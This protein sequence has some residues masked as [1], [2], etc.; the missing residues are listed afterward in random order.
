MGLVKDGYE[1]F[2]LG[3]HAS[4]ELIGGIA[5][6]EAVLGPLTECNPAHQTEAR[7]KVINIPRQIIEREAKY[8]HRIVGADLH[9][10]SKPYLRISRPGEPADNIG[11]H[12]DTWYGDTPYEMSVWIPFTNTDEGNALRVAPGSH[13]WSEREHPVIAYDA[14]V[15]QGSEKHALG[16]AYAP[17]RLATAVE[18]IPVPMK[19]GQALVF[20]VSLLHGVEVNT[21]AHTRVSMDCRVANSFAPIRLSRSRDKHYYERLCSAP[22]T[23]LARRYEANQ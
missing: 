21:S 6:L 5:K 2:W 14:G 19:V 15:E 16:F 20:P 17:K 9:I 4:T 7:N 11:L 3:K 8:F 10:Q 18:T 1:V 12:R 23:E 13:L 22:L